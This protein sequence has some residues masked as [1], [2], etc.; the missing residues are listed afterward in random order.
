MTAFRLILPPSTGTWQ[1]KAGEVEK[2]VEIA[3][4]AGYKLLDC[5]A[6]YGNENEVGE[7]IRQSGV[8]PDDIWITS[9]V[10][11][12]H[13]LSL[14]KAK[15][16]PP[17][18]LLQLW[19]NSHNPEYVE[20]AC[21]K[22]LKDLGVKHLDLYLMHWPSAFKPGGEMIP[23]ENGVALRDT[24][25][26]LAQ[27]WAEMEKLLEK[28]KVKNIGISNFTRSEVEELLKTAKHKPDAI[29]IELHP[30]LQQKEFVEWCQSLG[31]VV[32]AYSPL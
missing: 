4:K 14:I 16:N 15:A 30:Y 28:G 21:D 29:Q 13:P 25:T 23:K 18:S 20:A 2:A 27:T 6:I 11:H 26:T 1:A 24:E 8:N 9:K 7:G 32:T 10:D 31:M 3:L 5:A 12:F 19:N 17:L 22:T